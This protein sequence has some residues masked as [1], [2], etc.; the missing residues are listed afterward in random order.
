MTHT[1]SCG[2]WRRSHIG[3]C[4]SEYRFRYQDIT[5]TVQIGSSI[6]EPVTLKYGVP[7]GSVLGPILFTM[8]TTRL[9]NIIRNHSLDFHLYADETQLYIS[10]KP[11][12]S[13]SRQT[14]ISQ[15]E[16]CIK[17]IKTWVTTN[18]VKLNYDKTDRIIFTTSETTSRQEDIVIHPLHQVWNHTETLVS[19]L[20]QPIVFMIMWTKFA[21]I[22]TI[23]CIPSVKFES[24]LANTRLKNDKF[25]SDIPFRLLQQPSVWYQWIFSY[26]SYNSARIMLRTFSPYGRNM[27]I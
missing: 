11:C 16:A 4:R 22:L 5:Q 26:L 3:T 10:F 12:D 23:S 21:E 1:P 13:I 19:C 27:T 9:G 20:I 8:Y 6:S 7:Q 14:A 17:D 18:L 2:F 25:G 24:T 15:V